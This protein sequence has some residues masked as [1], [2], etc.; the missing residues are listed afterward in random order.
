MH[1]GTLRLGRM[2]LPAGRTQ[3]AVKALS[4]PG[5]VVM[6]LKEAALLKTR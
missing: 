2:G 1:W 5:A 6:D 3:L 4:K